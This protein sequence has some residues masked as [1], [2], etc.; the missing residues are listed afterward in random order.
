[1]GPA[2]DKNK[3]VGPKWAVKLLLIQNNMQSCLNENDFF[4]FYNLWHELE[5]E[6]DS[7]MILI[8]KE[9][10][11]VVSKMDKTMHYI[12]GVIGDDPAID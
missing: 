9:L 7:Q 5:S 4:G 3:G 11:T 8:D 12:L 6:C 10:L 2:L 1:M